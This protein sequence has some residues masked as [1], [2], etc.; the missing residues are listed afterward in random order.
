MI[1][2]LVE[3]S[4]QI[5]Y[6]YSSSFWGKNAFEEDNPKLGVEPRSNHFSTYCLKDVMRIHLS[7]EMVNVGDAES[8]SH[9]LDYDI[10]K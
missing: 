9:I 4:M 1:L 7:E 5:S 6:D 3:E 8:D 10:P 2:E